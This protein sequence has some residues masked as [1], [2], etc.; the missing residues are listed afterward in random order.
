MSEGRNNKL[1]NCQDA[2]M[3]NGIRSF[4]DKMV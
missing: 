4:V 1:K 2:K 3:Q